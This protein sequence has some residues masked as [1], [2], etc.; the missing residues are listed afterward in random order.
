[1]VKV[2]PYCV[3][4]YDRNPPRRKDKDGCFIATAA[5]GSPMAQELDLLRGWRDV[6][7]SSIYIGRVF[8]GVYYRLSPP[9]A[10]FIEKRDVLRMITRTL[11]IIPVAVL[12]NRKKKILWKYD[13]SYTSV[14]ICL[15]G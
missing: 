12:K 8:I 13:V 6:E 4:G 5:Y 3:G 1:M 10:R 2:K 15:N 9:I 7:L 14:K 11:L